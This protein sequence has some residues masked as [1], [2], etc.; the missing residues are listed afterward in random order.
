MSELRVALLIISAGFLA[1]LTWWESRRPRQAHAGNTARRP[2]REPELPPPAPARSAPD[3]TLVLPEIRAHEPLTRHELPVVELR[4]DAGAAAIPAPAAAALPAA[5]PE[6][7]AEEACAAPA[8]D[9]SADRER[10][11][12]DDLDEDGELDVDREL[13]ADSEPAPA[14]EE[15]AP[16]APLAHDE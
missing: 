15:R 10:D 4:F 11:A 3:S 7:A 9:Q 1:G 14:A 16:A 13:S 5:P 8:V 12:E 6:S 2:P